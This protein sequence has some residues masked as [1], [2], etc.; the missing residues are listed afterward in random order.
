MYSMMSMWRGSELVRF[1]Y[2]FCWDSIYPI[3][4]DIVFRSI[5]WRETNSIQSTGATDRTAQHLAERTEVHQLWTVGHWDPI[6]GETVSVKIIQNHAK[7]GCD[8]QPFPSK[9]LEMTTGR[10]LS[11]SKNAPTVWNSARSWVRTL[12]NRVFEMFDYGP[13]CL[14]LDVWCI[15]Y[16]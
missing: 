14:D 10:M 6:R 2:S 13:R 5:H 4:I 1:V 15:D 9:T 3:L 11:C 8:S 16:M 12:Q 7:S